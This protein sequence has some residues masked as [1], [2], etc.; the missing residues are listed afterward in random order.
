M[1]WTPL[2][3]K[4]VG[5]ETVDGTGRL[6]R[7]GRIERLSG[8]SDFRRKTPAGTP[9]ATGKRRATCRTPC[10]PTRTPR[11]CPC[12]EGKGKCWLVAHILTRC[13]TPSDAMHVPCAEYLLCAA[14]IQ[15]VRVVFRFART[16]IEATG[17]Y[18]FLDSTTR[19]GALHKAGN[20]KL[21]VRSSNGKTA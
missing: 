7:E 5:T 3:Q 14:S 16:E 6:F 11:C 9:V 20:T 10:R 8:W 4:A 15:Q 1:P 18:R 12:R 19:I 13:M 21:R 2:N 17:E